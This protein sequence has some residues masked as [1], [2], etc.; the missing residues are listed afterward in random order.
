MSKRIAVIAIICLAAI[1]VGVAYV[2]MR[3][4]GPLRPV[5]NVERGWKTASSSGLYFSYPDSFEQK[6]TRAFDWP[7]SFS[8]IAEPYACGEAGRPEERAGETKKI[9][10]NDR[11]YCRT[12][13]IEG[14][15]GSRYSQ[16]AYAFARG[17]QTAVMTF[18]TQAPNCGN[19]DDPERTAC[20][21]E[22]SKFDMD[23]LADRIIRTIR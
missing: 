10:V 4:R 16:Y 22:Q 5:T 17:D 12:V 23:K 15:A 8:V 3:P 11:E 13:V 1:A 2:S 18:T 6:Y 21:A 9:A 7:P 14:A 19:Y 20:E